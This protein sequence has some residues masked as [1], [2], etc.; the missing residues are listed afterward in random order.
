[1]LAALEGAEFS[2][3]TWWPCDH[4]K[5]KMIAGIVCGVHASRNTHIRTLFTFKLHF[6]GLDWGQAGLSFS[7]GYLHQT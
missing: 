2:A 1:M 3:V 5:K 7:Q 6:V 4:N